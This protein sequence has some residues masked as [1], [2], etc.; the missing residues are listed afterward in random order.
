MTA[1]IIKFELQPARI[2]KRVEVRA[3]NALDLYFSAWKLWLTMWGV[4]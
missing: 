2:V 1:D 3:S 4:L